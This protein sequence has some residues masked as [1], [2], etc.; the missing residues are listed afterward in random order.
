MQHQVIKPEQTNPTD[1]VRL[2]KWDVFPF[3]S[4]AHN[5]IISTNWR[6]AC[7]CDCR[8]DCLPYVSVKLF[9]MLENGNPC[10]FHWQNI[11]LILFR[12]KASKQCIIYL[13]WVCQRNGG[14]STL[15]GQ[16][17]RVKTAFCLKNR[18]CKRSLKCI[19]SIIHSRLSKRTDRYDSPWVSQTRTVSSLP[20]L[21]YLIVPF[22]SL[23]RKTPDQRDLNA[24]FVVVTLRAASLSSLNRVSSCPC[25]VAVLLS[26]C[27]SPPVLRGVT[28][29]TLGAC[30]GD[31]DGPLS[32]LP[33]KA[34]WLQSI[35]SINKRDTSFS[36]VVLAVARAGGAGWVRLPAP[37]QPSEMTVGSCTPASSWEAG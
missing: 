28:V 3:F 10:S 32:L 11:V 37:P 12:Q 29:K 2:Q 23:C 24:G 19:W 25:H 31:A 33:S 22:F 27:S 20:P 8:S 18:W 36:W 9:I 5:T 1:W 35:N 7:K 21:I 4:N 6:C 34:E 13:I 26:H 14:Q 15:K 30:D 16:T 17:F